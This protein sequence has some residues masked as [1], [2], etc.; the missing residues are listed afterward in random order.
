LD[1]KYRQVQEKVIE[2]DLGLRPGPAMLSRKRDVHVNVP[3]FWPGTEVARQY[4]PAIA[5]AIASLASGRLPQSHVAIVGNLDFTDNFLRSLEAVAKPSHVIN[6]VAQGFRQLVA[7]RRAAVVDAMV[8]LLGEAGIELW[9]DEDPCA[10]F[11]SALPTVFGLPDSAEPS[12]DREEVGT[13]RTQD[14]LH[15]SF[16]ALGVKFCA[17]MP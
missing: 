1:L 12:E 10:T 13:V 9:V 15:L 5:V 16:Y 8:D 2:A 14:T 3:N 4:A 17:C 7:P 11:S 6:L